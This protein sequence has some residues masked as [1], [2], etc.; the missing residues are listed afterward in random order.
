MK[1]QFKYFAFISYN[2]K[3]T[4]W[5]KKIQKKLEHYRMPATMCSEHGWKRKPLQPIFFAPTDIQP[6]D[7]TEEIQNRLRASRNLIV[8]CSPNSA[9]SSWVGRE[10]EFFHELGRT[11]DIYFFIVNGIPHSGDPKTECF[12]S[13][14]DSIGFPEILAANINEKNYRWPWINRERGYVQLISKLLDVEFDTIWHR[15]KRLLIRKILLYITLCIV[16]IVSLIGIWVVNKPIDVIVNLNETSVSNNHLPP[17]KNAII[18]LSLDNEIKTDTFK[19]L[20]TQVK[21]NNIPHYYL[22]KPVHFT[23]KSRDYKEVDTILPLTNVQPL[24]IMRDP[25]IYGDV[26]F[27]IYDPEKEKGISNVKIIINGFETISDSKGYV[28]LFIPLENQNIFYTIKASNLL[29]NDTIYMP[30][31]DNDVVL[32]NSII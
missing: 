27:R 15:H 5:G 17:L 32:I 6:G 26:H 28:S 8:L 2:S 4:N 1:K 3:D 20:Q 22:G 29:F 11:K 7:L 21:F 30:S 16:M 31:G 13:V 9:S 14:I 23:V 12:N 19:T 25:S 24:S 10:I 18:T